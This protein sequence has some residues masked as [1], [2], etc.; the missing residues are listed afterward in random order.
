MSYLHKLQSLLTPIN[1]KS[2]I[3]VAVTAEPETEL[4][5]TRAASGYQGT[6]IV[7]PANI[8]ATELGRRG[9]LDV[10][11][12]SKSG[13]QHGMAQPA[14]LVLKGHPVDEVLFKWAIVPSFVSTARIFLIPIIVIS[15]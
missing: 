6:V 1:T 13:Y 7:D 5:R 4:P 12:T 3:V 11:V 14:V 2:G 9:L 15:S 10:A 8:L